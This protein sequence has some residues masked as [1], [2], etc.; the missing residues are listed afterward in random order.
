M[1]MRGVH[2]ERRRRGV[3]SP[4]GHATVFLRHHACAVTAPFAHAGVARSPRQE[5]GVFREAMGP[6]LRV[7][8]APHTGASLPTSSSRARW[9]VDTPRAVARLAAERDASLAVPEVVG[10][11]AFRMLLSLL[12]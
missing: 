10:S 1:P 9:Q 12:K 5:F 4:A 2:A 8:G 6:P 7:A 3:I 11:A